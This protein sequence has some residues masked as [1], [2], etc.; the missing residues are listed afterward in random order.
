MFE[1][2]RSICCPQQQIDSTESDK[3]RELRVYIENARLAVE[4]ELKLE[5]TLPDGPPVLP[6]MNRGTRAF[7][8]AGDGGV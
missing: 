3:Q 8:E 5:M 2:L 6:V 4:H 7:S 1:T